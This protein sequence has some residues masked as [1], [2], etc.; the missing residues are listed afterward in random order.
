MGAITVLLECSRYKGVEAYAEDVVES[1]TQSVMAEYYRP[2]YEEYHLLFLAYE[3]GKYA[4]EHIQNKVAEYMSYSLKPSKKIEEIRMKKLLFPFVL[5]KLENLEVDNLVYATDQEGDIFQKEAVSYMK[6]KSID[7]GLQKLKEG[8]G[9]VN[10]IKSS[11][12]ILKKKMDCEEK[13]QESALNQVELMRLID[14]V[15]VMDITNGRGKVKIRAEEAFVKMFIV[16]APSQKR[17]GIANDTVWK[18]VKGK[19][20]NVDDLLRRIQGGG[21]TILELQEQSILLERE[22]EKL[23]EAKE[24]ADNKEK[25]RLLDQKIREVNES[26]EEQLN[27]IK[28]RCERFSATLNKV[29]DK[30]EEALKEIE[31]LREGEKEVSGVL[32]E[33]KEK[34]EQSKSEMDSELYAGLRDDLAEMNGAV[35]K[36]EDGINYEELEQQLKANLEIL[37]AMHGYDNL[38]ITTQYAS[39]H[40][41]QSLAASY[42]ALLQKYEVSSIRFH[43]GAITENTV[44]SPIDSLKELV[45]NGIADLVLPEG[46]VLSKQVLN[47]RNVV[48]YEEDEKDENV[49]QNIMSNLDVTKNV[50]KIFHLFT[51]GAE[52]LELD[53]IT[54]PIGMLFYKEEHF[55]DFSDRETGKEKCLCYEL[56]YILNGHVKDS[57]N[58][59]ASINQLM[60]WKTAF[61]FLSIM[62]DSKKKSMAKETAVLIA[63]ITGIQPLVYVTQTLILLTWAFE[64]ALVDVAAIL[65]DKQV[66]ILKKSS[67]FLLTYSELVALNRQKVQEKAKQ[68]KEMRQG[69]LS[70]ELY[71]EVFLLFQGGNESNLRCM[72]LINSNMKLCHNKEFD[73][74]NCVYS[75][76]LLADM[77]A[78][79]KFLFWQNNIVLKRQE[80][81]GKFQII[82]KKNY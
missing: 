10:S 75:Y 72:N 17:M 16:G 44:K 26:I 58:M 30:T 22:Q 60:T 9:S 52:N 66:P 39:L 76:E 42:L 59:E 33:Y 73:L 69:G 27:Y 62:T 78:Q 11:T 40:C 49:I 80:V 18:K 28:E 67:E 55:N 82:R 65:Q 37:N 31:K 25:R 15:N 7:K 50:S 29:E 6:Y 24:E 81:L 47:E 56:E 57:D 70:Y 68:V 54:D 23:K 74:R 20:V 41:I 38:S 61:N 5:P 79:K 51:D 19:Y 13:I 35:G 34:L 8:L 1:A 53:S 45:S 43:Y 77:D 46:E 64:E 3:D 32:S 36:S 12:E 48:F 4:Q 71:L 21:K 14:G 2:L 63:G